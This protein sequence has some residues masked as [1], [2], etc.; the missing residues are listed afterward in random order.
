MSMPVPEYLDPNNP[1][2]ATGPARLDTGTI[3]MPQLGEVAVLTVR[4]SSATQT[5]MLSK[6][7]LRKWRTLIDKLDD[8]VNGPVLEKATIADVAALDGSIPFRKRSL[9]WRHV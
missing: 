2:L 6:D 9:R 3:T 1:L 8:S 4:S 7:D 5:V